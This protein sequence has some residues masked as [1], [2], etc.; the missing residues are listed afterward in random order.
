MQWAASLDAQFTRL[1]A[2][3]GDGTVC[4]G[5]PAD[6]RVQRLF[7][8]MPIMSAA[9]ETVRRDRRLDVLVATCQLVVT[10]GID[11]VRSATVAATAKLSVG[12]V[13]YYYPTL[14]D[15]ML[16]AFLW[17]EEQVL[18]PLAGREPTD[19]PLGTLELLLSGQFARSGPEVRASFLLWQEYARRAMI[20][21]RI[22]E[23]VV[24]RIERWVEVMAELVRAAA[25][26]GE[27]RE[28]ADALT[29]ARSFAAL[30]FGA[31]ALQLIELIPVEQAQGDLA[32]H[33]E[34]SAAGSS[35]P[36]KA[37]HPVPQSPAAGAP[38]EAPALVLDATLELVARGG[39]RGVH[40]AE[41]GTRAGFST[42]LPRYYFPNMPTLLAAAFSRFAERRRERMRRLVATSAD[43]RERVRLAVAALA[44]MDAAARRD[45]LFIWHEFVRQ[46]FI[47]GDARPAVCA[48]VRDD[49]DALV[50]LLIEAQ[51]AAAD[52]RSAA[53]RL[54]ELAD[55][56]SLGGLLGILDVDETGRI[57]DWAVADELDAQ[58]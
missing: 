12:T 7:G 32:F 35:R 53:R 13:H 15:L 34:R 33:V 19:D 23:V 10:D 24:R 39:L 20:D 40:F 55:G 16:A 17:D 37:A 1:G 46:A 36:S 31:S 3:G 56:V 50:G 26:R 25:D 51:P 41:V 54:V 14:D 11:G 58:R 5:A 42:A 22:R 47:H 52:P 57:L 38:T 18:D 21:E 28:P 44:A 45:E 8:M 48:A 43:P 49:I 9:P 29:A 6:P 27:Y 2:G 30:Q 4:I